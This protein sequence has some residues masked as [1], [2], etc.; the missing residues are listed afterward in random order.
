MGE[1]TSKFGGNVELELN[2]IGMQVYKL[3]RRIRVYES[4][5]PEPVTS[6][7]SFEASATARLVFFAS[8]HTAVSWIAV[9]SSLALKEN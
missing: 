6:N 1:K 9:P 3:F 7:W 5:I 8:L 4:I 2:A